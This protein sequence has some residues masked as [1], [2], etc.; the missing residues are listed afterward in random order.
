[1][2]WRFSFPAS[3]VA[4]QPCSWT[5]VWD[6]TYG[7]MVL[8]QNGAIVS[9]N[10]YRIEG[11]ENVIG[12]ITGNVSGDTL[13]GSWERP[14]GTYGGTISF[15]MQE[16][17]NSFLG[18]TP[19]LTWNGNR[20]AISISKTASPTEVAN[21]YGTIE[22]IIT[23][24]NTGGATLDDIFVYDLK[25]NPMNNPLNNNAIILAPGGHW[26]DSYIWDIPPDFQGTVNTARVTAQAVTMTDQSGM[27]HHHLEASDSA[28]VDRV[29]P[30]IANI[31]LVGETTYLVG[32]TVSINVAWDTNK[33]VNQAQWHY[34]VGGDTG[35]MTPSKSGTRELTIPGLPV[36]SYELFYR[37]FYEE[38]D[39][40]ILYEAKE[41][42]A[43]N[44][45][46]ESENGE[47]VQ[48]EPVQEEQTPT[49]AAAPAPVVTEVAALETYTITAS[50]GSGGTIDPAG[51][52]DVAEGNDQT[53]S[54]KAKS[55]Y[56]ISDVLVDGVSVGAVSSY[57]FENVQSN[58]TIYV[59]FG[60]IAPVD[61]PDV[62][63]EEPVVDVLGIDELPYT[64]FD[65]MYAFMGLGMLLAGSGLMLA[66]KKLRRGSA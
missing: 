10:Y 21:D 56:E 15:T 23:V 53:F 6:T 24:T 37:I 44:I 22:Y 12:Y 2:H 19:G 49:P 4:D 62:V 46:E 5:G 8:E 38:T 43:I 55:G 34:G 32:E 33:D 41:T 1:M 28:T 18:S 42:I 48:E 66:L 11:G 7:V 13:I 3:A 25:F 61:K 30:F 51:V 39:G 26:Q 31:S 58:H 16:G 20:I 60:Y 52:I 36:G 64:G 45:I 40:T 50:T 47:P 27:T 57:T 9:G 14:P 54:I 35:S 63:E 65:L 59:D 29:V 17:C